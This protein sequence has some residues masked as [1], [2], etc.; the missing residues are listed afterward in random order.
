MADL[1][2]LLQRL[3]GLFDTSPHRRL[4]MD[5][6]FR[7][8]VLFIT[9]ALYVVVARVT[10]NRG[11]LLLGSLLALAGFVAFTSAVDRLMRLTGGRDHPS[12]V[13]RSAE[14]APHAA[15][16]SHDPEV[17]ASLLLAHARPLD[18]ILTLADAT[19]CLVREV[20][21]VPLPRVVN[22]LEALVRHQAIV[23]DFDEA[24]DQRCWRFPRAPS[25]ARLPEA[26]MQQEP[27]DR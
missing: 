2:S 4:V 22:A 8:T 15:G 25:A 1:T 14:H 17:L 18:G 5:V 23:P 26:S 11:E 27:R 20:G 6:T 12:V 9:I 24:T 16:S 10:Y 13:A 21:P 3:V 7:L 19:V